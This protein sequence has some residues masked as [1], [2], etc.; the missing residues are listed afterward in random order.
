MK[1]KNKKYKIPVSDDD[2]TSRSFYTNVE[3][4]N[5]F[6]RLGAFL[7]RTRGVSFNVSNFIILAMRDYY[8]KVVDEYDITP[9][10]HEQIS[11]KTKKR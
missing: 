8:K 9:E 2:K 4:Y 11:R 7:K 1:E 5:F 10:E 6:K 3:F